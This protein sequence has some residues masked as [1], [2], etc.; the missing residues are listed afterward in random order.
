MMREVWESSDR[1][2]SMQENNKNRGKER[3]QA[4][5]TFSHYFCMFMCKKVAADVSRLMVLV[6]G[7]MRKQEARETINKII[8]R[9]CRGTETPL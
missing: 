9:A 3:E 1:S 6:S 8:K 4:T 7:K 2:C 5:V